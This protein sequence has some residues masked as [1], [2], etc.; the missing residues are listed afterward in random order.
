V[1]QSFYARIG[2]RWFD[3]FFSAVGLFLLSPFLLLVA[4]AVRLESPGS[5]FFFQ[6]RTGR[7]AKAFRIVKFRTMRAA[8]SG[9]S[10]LITASGDSRI[11]R[12]GRWLRKTKVDELP[13]LVNV[14][15]GDMSLVGPRPEVP[16]YTVLYNQEQS[17]VFVARPGITGPAAILCVNEEEVLAEQKDPEEYYVRVLLPTKLDIDLAY[18]RDLSLRQ[19]VLLI[20]RTFA[21]IFNKQ[22]LEVNLL[23]S[24]ARSTADLK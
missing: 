3:V 7:F 10:P 6:T 17:W 5:S 9:H 1:N 16:K 4:I 8:E 11:T 21:R 23:R 14:I 2:K 19:D 15:R 13:Q 22:Q 12:L 20:W 18:C 24:D